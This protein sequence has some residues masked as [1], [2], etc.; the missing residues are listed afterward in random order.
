MPNN[1]VEKLEVV[2]DTSAKSA[3]RSLSAM[4]RHLEKIAENLTLVTGLTKGLYNIGSVDVS[5]LKELKS[6]LDAIFKKQKNV[7]KEPT[8]PRVDRSDL[9]YTAKSLMNY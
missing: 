3:N 9:Q 1:E 7:N 2:I 4:E 8:K 6:D 5:G